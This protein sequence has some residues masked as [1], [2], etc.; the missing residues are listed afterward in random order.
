MQLFICPW[1]KFIYSILQ[2]EVM[3]DWEH[4]IHLSCWSKP[5]EK[6]PLAWPVKEL[7]RSSYKI[8]FVASFSAL[9]SESSNGRRLAVAPVDGKFKPFVNEQLWREAENPPPRRRRLSSRPIRKTQD[10]DQVKKC[11]WFISWLWKPLNC[12]SSEVVQLFCDIGP[13]DFLYKFKPI[14]IE[15]F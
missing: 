1:S 11:A 12:V 14:F 10:S 2:R 15:I 3:R 5:P 6:L 13:G 8:C 4:F 7:L 9:Q